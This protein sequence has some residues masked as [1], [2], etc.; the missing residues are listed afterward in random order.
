MASVASVSQGASYGERA[1]EQHGSEFPTNGDTSTF[2]AFLDKFAEGSMPL[3]DSGEMRS[4]PSFSDEAY[5]CQKDCSE[6]SETTTKTLTNIVMEEDLPHQAPQYD[7]NGMSASPSG[8]TETCVNSCSIDN[9]KD[10]TAAETSRAFDEIFRSRV[11]LHS[12]VRKITNATYLRRMHLSRED[13]VGLFPEVKGSVE[14]VSMNKMTRR[15]YSTP[16]KNGTL[17]CIN[18]INGKRWP[19]VLE[20]LRT[21]GQRHIRFN[22]GWAK[23]CSA[24]GLSI[25]K[26]VR[27][28]RWKHGSSSGDTLVTFSVV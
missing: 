13:A 22:K 3:S 15:E 25:G 5:G 23:M 2:A 8:S 12:Y 1:L 27:L 16:L 18:D 28:A 24:N 4:V 19:V 6:T 14:F 10:R 17:V 20:C 26:C 21:A 9:D 11:V 7:Y